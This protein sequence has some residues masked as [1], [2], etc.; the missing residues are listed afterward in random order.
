MA[1]E[2]FALPLALISL[3]PGTKLQLEESRI[4]IESHN[5]MQITTETDMLDLLHPI[6]K[7]EISNFLENARN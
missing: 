6:T 1:Q 3:P 7:E 4:L 2:K 5:T